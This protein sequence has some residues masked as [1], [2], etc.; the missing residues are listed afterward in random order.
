[1]PAASRI[2]STR[3]AR[4]CKPAPMCICAPWPA[5]GEMSIA[6]PK[7]RWG[8]CSPHNRTIRY[9]WRVVMAPPAVIDYLAAHEVDHLVNADHSPAYWPVVQRLVGDQR[10]FRK[11]CATMG[12]R[13]TRW[14]VMF[15]PMSVANGRWL[16]GVADETEGATR[17]GVS[18][19]PAPP[20]SPLRHGAKAR[21][22][23]FPSAMGGDWSA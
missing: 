2:C 8:S 7:S 15:I 23:T 6:D 22:A 17:G 13:C 9:S 3:G 4:P 18:D 5:S 1:M 20:T 10:P 16:G 14:A 19:P 12:R 11:C 21:R